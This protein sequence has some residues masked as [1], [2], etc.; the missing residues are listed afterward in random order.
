MENEGNETPGEEETPDTQEGMIDAL[1]EAL[2]I[3]HAVEEG[4]ETEEEIDE[5]EGD[6]EEGEGDEGALDADGNPISKLGKTPEGIGD[7]NADGTFK[8]PAKTLDPVNDP[9]PEGLK[10][11]TNQRIRS[12]I[13]MTKAA[14]AERD[15]IRT[16]FDAIVNG[17]KASGSTPE[18]YGEAISWLS[19]FNDPNP[20]S[21]RKAYELVE[22]VAD[23]MATMMGIDR[24]IG[25]PLEQHADLKTLVANKQMTAEVAREVARMRNGQKFSGDVQNSVRE[26]E[27]AA[28]R[29]AAEDSQARAGL[30][31]FAKEMEA[32][33]PLW[34]RKRKALVPTLKETF[35]HI[36]KSK[37]VETFKAAYQTVR[38]K[39]QGTNPA[40]RQNGGGGAGAGGNQPLRGGKNPAGG[41]GQE[42][43]TMMDA[44][45]GALDSLKR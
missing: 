10:P 25:D 40:L 41:R 38:I 6:E 18:Q 11:E 22:Q 27:Q 3:E 19:L 37:W 28:A 26:K 33:D 20:E 31:A 7:R 34:D 43:A 42:P 36:P 30:N 13:D 15:T 17:I 32:S 16:D 24:K 2:G 4:E 39:P 14:T 1:D 29:A 9:I 35:K 45:N 44:L 8:K 5:G 23:R 12:L 21:Q